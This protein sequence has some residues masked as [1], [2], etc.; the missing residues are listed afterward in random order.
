M[1]LS[2]FNQKFEYFFK[3]N[4]VLNE[5]Y[6]CTFVIVLQWLFAGEIVLL[7]SPQ[8]VRVCLCSTGALHRSCFIVLM[9]ILNANDGIDEED[10]CGGRS[11]LVD[12]QCGHMS[13]FS[14][15][16]CQSLSGSSSQSRILVLSGKYSI[17]FYLAT[18][19]ANLYL[20]I[21]L[22][23]ESFYLENRICYQVC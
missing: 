18:I 3:T 2:A 7:L 15:H 19:N 6:H 5:I 20:D 8:F 11:N 17:Q 14:V 4:K 22:N 10:E 21:R 12:D 9:M 1:S 16:Q 23:L 13:A